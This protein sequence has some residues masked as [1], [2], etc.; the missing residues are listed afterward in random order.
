MG[1]IGLH[2]KQFYS[3][4]KYSSLQVDFMILLSSNPNLGHQESCA[5]CTVSLGQTLKC[6]TRE[7][8]MTCQ[9]SSC[10]RSTLL[11]QVPLEARLSNIKGREGL[12]HHHCGRWT[13]CLACTSGRGRSCSVALTYRVTPNTF[14][15]EALVS[16]EGVPRAT[17]Y[18]VS[19]K[20]GKHFA[21]WPGNHC[22]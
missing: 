17:L 18:R 8:V 7:V 16:V 12:D 1:R 3:P 9:P 10:V 21:E 20:F 11:A 5:G 2:T 4:Y 14:R 22:A 13:S 19:H 6:H 15:T